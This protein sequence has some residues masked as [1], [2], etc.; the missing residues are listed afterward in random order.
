MSG[1]PLVSIITVNYDQPEVT[2]QLLASLERI[3][4]AN[5]EV[6]VVDNASPNRGIDGLIARFPSVHFLKSDQNLGFA[7]GNN[8]G[9]QRSKGKHLLFLNNDTEVHPDF[10]QPLVD[11]LETRPD[12]GM[13]S[14]KIKFFHEENLIQYAGSGEMNPY[15]GRSFFRGNRQPDQGQFD[16]TSPTAFVHGAAMLVSRKVL[17]TSGLMHEPYFL[18]YEEFDWCA[19]ARRDGFSTWYVGESVV[20]HKESVST[21]KESPFKLYYQTRNRLYYMRRNAPPVQREVFLLYFALISAPKNSFHFLFTRRF[22]Y[23]KAFWRG[24]W[25]NLTYQPTTHEHRA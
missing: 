10:L 2:A 20:Y 16:A 22:D 25:W 7:G 18:Y 12:A 11:C 24:L 1:S 9:I 17:T 21:G 19:R 13:A 5:F 15:T 14:P 6:I 4:Y 3:R 8:L 23:L